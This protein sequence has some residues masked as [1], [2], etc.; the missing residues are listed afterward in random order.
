M[1][2]IVVGSNFEKKS[3][4]SGFRQSA[5]RLLRTWLDSHLAEVAANGD[6]LPLESESLEPSPIF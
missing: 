3:G 6:R 1:L 2:L 4:Y 5:D